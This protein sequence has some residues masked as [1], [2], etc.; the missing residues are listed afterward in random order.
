[1]FTESVTIHSVSTVISGM[2]L[3]STPYKYTLALGSAHTK[4]GSLSVRSTNFFLY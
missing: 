4:Y 2:H 1:M 3:T